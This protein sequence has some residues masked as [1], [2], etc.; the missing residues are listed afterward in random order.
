M[1]SKIN[2]S[3]SYSMQRFGELAKQIAR[4]LA[5]RDD[6][7]A[8]YGGCNFGAYQ[9][10]F[11]CEP[12]DGHE[13][14]IHELLKLDAATITPAGAAVGR[15]GSRSMP[16]SSKRVPLRRWEHQGIGYPMFTLERLVNVAEILRG[17]GFDA[18]D[19][20]GRHGQSIEAAIAY[21]ACLGKGS[22]FGKTVTAEN[23]GACPNAPQYFGKVASG[24]GST[25]NLWGLSLSQ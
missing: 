6:W 10:A 12:Q 7:D 11:S 5:A 8:A 18:Y 22:G 1:A 21:Y 17:A 9:Y 2:R 3:E 19:Y 16:L 14:A 13:V 15:P 4:D 20:R 25:R 24:M 23:S